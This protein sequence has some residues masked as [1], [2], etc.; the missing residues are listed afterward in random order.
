MWLV[1]AA[2]DAQVAAHGEQ[3]ARELVR[4]APLGEEEGWQWAGRLHD[5]GKI[6]LPAALIYKRGALTRRERRTIEEHSLC[7]A[8]LLKRL[9]APQVVID[10]AKYHHE[11]WDGTGYP[12]DIGQEQIPLVARCLAIA[13]AYTVLRSDRPYRRAVSPEQARAEIERHAGTQFDPGLV[14]IFF[15]NHGNENE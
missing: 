10:G 9:G 6:A 2:W 12:Y 4:F 1:L 15:A 11:R 14:Q 7:G 5:L 13:D 8:A 3:V